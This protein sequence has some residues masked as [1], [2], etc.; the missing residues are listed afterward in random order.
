VTPLD[1]ASRFQIPP[2]VSVEPFGTGLLHA[3]HEVSTRDG[4]FV[5]QRLDPVIA[6]AAI[7]D[8]CIVGEFLASRGFRVPVPRL[9]KDGGVLVRDG[10][11]RWR[12]Y[13]MIAGQA[14]DVV[15]HPEM[16]RE[17]GCIVGEMHRHLRELDYEPQGGIPHFHDTAFILDELRSVADRLPASVRRIAGLIVD[18]LP[19]LIID[20]RSAGEPAMVIHGDLKISNLLFDEGRAVAVIDMD[21]LMRHFRVIDLGDA[22]RSW[23]AT[24]TEDD[25]GLD[26]VAGLFAA[27]VDGYARGWGGPVDDRLLLRATRQIAWELSARFLIDTVRDNY[28]GFDPKKY[29]SR[30]DHN[31]ARALAQFRLGEAVACQRREFWR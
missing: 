15:T 12:L 14:F 10:G 9:S 11:D 5:L 7:R 27:A 29:A 31:M 3:T 19:A 8:A 20:A 26:F 2:P 25:P 22:F 4:A 6:D 24:G 17:A 23:C 18:E 30:R 16:A 1:I 28:F 13:P 21:T